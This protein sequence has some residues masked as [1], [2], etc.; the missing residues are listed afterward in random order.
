MTVYVD[1]LITWSAKFGPSCHLTA[2]TTDELHVFARKIGL[3]RT[4]CSDVTQP[5]EQVIHYDLKGARMR[6]KALAGGAVFVPGIEQA[7]ARVAAMKARMEA[8][9]AQP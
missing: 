4:W 2:D 9:H 5:R 1:E 3:R 6:D 7:R 8:I